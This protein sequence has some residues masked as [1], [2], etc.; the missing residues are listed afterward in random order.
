[1]GWWPISILDVG[2]CLALTMVLFTGPLFEKGLV[3]QELK[4]WVRLKGVRESLGS[5]VGWRHYVAVS[6]SYFY[7]FFFHPYC[8]KPSSFLL[9]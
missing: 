3:E 5:W 1:M 2:K 6:F 9:Y 4:D 7:Q 8:S